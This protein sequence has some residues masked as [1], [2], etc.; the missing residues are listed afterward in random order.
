MIDVGTEILVAR[1]RKKLKQK[2]LAKTAGIHAC[3]L[4]R[5]EKNLK[6]PKLSTLEQVAAAMGMKV[7]VRFVEK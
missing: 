3:T 7:E 1:K 4:N 2:E 5:F 6:L